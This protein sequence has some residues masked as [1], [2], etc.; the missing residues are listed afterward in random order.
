[1]EPQNVREEDRK[2][3]VEELVKEQ[4]VHRTG[5]QEGPFSIHILGLGRT[6][7]SVIEQLLQGP[8]TGFLEDPH[9]RFTALAVDIGDEDLDPVR[10]AAAAAELP[11]ERAQLRT[12]AM[13][14]PS[15][16]DFFASLRRY[17]EYLKI[18]YPRYYWNP[19]YEPWLPEDIEMPAAED[20]F[21]RAVA[22]GIYNREYYEDGPIARELDAF[23]QSI[24]ASE[25]VPI[26]F[27]VF[28][29]AG[30]TGSGMVVDIARHLS[31]IKLGRRH[32]L[33]GI[34]VLPSEGDAGETQDGVLFP[35]L[36]ELDCMLDQEKNDGVQTVWGDLYRNPFSGG[37]FVAP[38]TEY[39]DEGIVSFIAQENGL[40]IYETLK[41][42]N[43][44]NSPTDRMHPATRAPFTDHWV[45]I[46]LSQ[47]IDDVENLHASLKFMADG[48]RPEY[49][50]ARV[51]A[52]STAFDSEAGAKQIGDQISSAVTTLVKPDVIH[53]DTE[54]ESFV[55]I[56]MPRLT[57]LGLADFSAARD[58]YDQISWDEKILAHSWLLDLGTMLCE[59]STRFEGMAG[60]CIWGCACWVVVP[61]EAI[62]GEE[63]GER[64]A[65]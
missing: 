10:E 46:L 57:K 7:A 1:M 53:F 2:D 65:Y 18:E 44:L 55:H 17:R 49:V 27:V 35:V 37:F 4:E 6:G 40:H 26:V 56:S 30:G 38:Q 61:Y 36:N 39:V 14:A 16:D 50:E 23:A 47:K 33:V 13:E 52:P 62:R 64:V 58:A 48:V 22:K 43:W 31:S 21:P 45:N 5:D 3:R 51:L 32:I 63:A 15:R 11:E 41:L 54:D 12:V 24:N 28:N 9:T 60:E 25:T 8:P 29:L 42:L 20:H 19:N 34:G 59:P